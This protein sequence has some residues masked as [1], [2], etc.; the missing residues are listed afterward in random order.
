MLIMALNSINGEYPWSDYPYWLESTSETVYSVNDS[1]WID[2]LGSNSYKVWTKVSVPAHKNISFTIERGG[3]NTPN[4]NNVFDF[5]DDFE[6]WNGWTKYRSGKVIQTSDYVKSGSYA[7]KKIGSNDPSGGYKDIGETLGRDI[8]VECWDY[9]LSGGSGQYDRVGVI[10]NSGNG[11]GMQ[12]SGSSNNL[13]IDRRTNY[14]ATLWT[15]S[16]THDREKWYFMQLIIKDDGGTLTSNLYDENLNLLGSYSHSDSTHSEFTRVYVFGGYYY[17]IDDL[18]IRKYADESNI[19]INISKIDNNKWNITIIDNNYY[20]LVDYQVGLDAVNDNS[21]TDKIYIT[22]TSDSLKIS[23]YTNTIYS[24]KTWT[25]VELPN[26]QTIRLLVKNYDNYDQNPDDVFEFFDDFSSF[27]ANKWDDSRAGNYEVNNG[28]IK[29]WKDWGAPWK[30]SSSFSKWIQT[31]TTFYTPF[32]VEYRGKTD[33]SDSGYGDN[34]AVLYGSSNTYVLVSQYVK[35]NTHPPII[36]PRISINGAPSN[37]NGKIPNNNWHNYDFTVESNRIT[38]HQDFYNGDYRRQGVLPTSGW[39]GIAGDT[40]KSNKYDYIDYLFVRK[41]ANPESTITVNQINNNEWI[42]KVDNEGSGD[43][44]NF[45]IP[46]ELQNLINNRLNISLLPSDLTINSVDL[47]STGINTTFT[48]NY[49]NTGDSSTMRDFIISLYADGAQMLNKTVSTL[50]TEDSSTMTFSYPT[51]DIYDKNLTIMVDSSNLIQESN[52]TNNNWTGKITELPDLTITNVD[53]ELSGTLVKFNIHYANQGNASAGGKF[54]ITLSTDSYNTS[55]EVNDLNIGAS[56]IL[57]LSAPIYDV[58][59]KQITIEIDSADNIYESNEGNNIY[60][61][62]E[63]PLPDLNITNVLIDQTDNSK[64]TFT[65]NY[66]NIGNASTGTGFWIGLF[67]NDILVDEEHVGELNKNSSSIVEL[68]GENYFGQ[69][70][71]YKIYIDY[72]GGVYE[73]NESNNIKIINTQ[74]PDLTITNAEKIDTG[75]KIK[76]N[77]TNIGD[78][79]VA[80]FSISLYIDDIEKYNTIINTPLQ[81]NQFIE[82]TLNWDISDISG[83]RE[84]YIMIDSGNNYIE[85]NEWNNIYYLQGNYEPYATFTYS[86]NGT[87][88]NFDASQS[89]DIDGNIAVYSWDFGD[90][91]SGSGVSPSHQYNKEGMYKVVLIVNDDGGKTGTTFRNIYIRESSI[92]GNSI[93]IP[94]YIQLLILLSTA[95]FVNNIMRGL[96]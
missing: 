42:V 24:Y 18:R 63:I 83:D 5:F 43:L 39:I 59:N 57:T 93:P 94:I 80:N 66:K 34:L 58:I 1:Y 68:E 86:L 52:E 75:T 53:T 32:T 11:Y 28:Y 67:A 90:G 78:T 19:I 84:V 70:G 13:G 72:R 35:T 95:Y 76:I 9:R 56:D 82:E 64:A 27:D 30:L 36:P 44:T 3:T 31:K 92:N 74:L 12:H 6:T 45:Q 61:V 29:M 22:S 23:S 21:A 4:G 49:K 73:T 62:S 40:D 37:Y 25:K 15:T 41:Y 88:V 54:T 46:F 26:E 50:N 79:D 8:I 2:D 89:K 20:D 33:Y 10:D 81:P 77:Y 91:N 85:L 60:T 69:V 65:V 48:V 96:K 71:Q 16:L 17:T 14:G 47:E 51:K 7:L 38:L 55:K 87:T